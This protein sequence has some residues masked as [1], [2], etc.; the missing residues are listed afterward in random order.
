V[1]RVFPFV[2]LLFD[3][4]R[5]GSLDLVTTPPY[6][7]ISP[8]ERRRFR[9]LSP[10]NVIRL[11]L[12]QEHTGGDP[13]NEYTRAAEELCRWRADGILRPTDGP[14]YYVYEMRFRLHGRP[15]RV[16][17]VVAAVELE[18]WGGS[19]LPH[20]RTMAAPVED[21]LRLMRAVGANLSCIQAVFPGPIPELAEALERVGAR[22]PDA[23]TTDEAGV[24]HRMWVVPP[25]ELDPAPW[26]ARESLMIADGHHRYEM[27]LRFRDEMRERHG[28]GP[29]DRVMMLLVDGTVEDPPV[30]PYHRILTEGD[31]GEVGERVLD[32]HEILEAV[33][34]ERLVYG[35][36]TL[37]R[38]V[39]S[40]HVVRLT[41]GEPPTVR[42][43]HRGALAG[44]DE[45]LR[46]THDAAEAE[47]AVRHGEARAAYILPPTTA[48]RIRSVVERGERLPE[49][50]TFFWPKPRSGMV[51]R[52]LDADA[53]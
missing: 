52:A 21:R 26:L 25:E 36:V 42:A 18:D 35:L 12:G 44:R 46:F 16:R 15:R 6:D 43:L 51:I 17:G 49:K 31:P 11:E 34:D 39:P 2:G 40:Y 47:D 27:S 28:P 45:H 48:A 1:S 9:D 30:L 3:R 19:I 20:E 5:V 53:G 38:G 8:A 33:D 23:R 13:G 14:A 10:Y 50:S 24:E 22:E 37:D 4:E 41:E 29:W 7:V 32:L